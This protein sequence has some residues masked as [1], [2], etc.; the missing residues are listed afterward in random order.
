[1]QLHGVASNEGVVGFN[2]DMS[3]IDEVFGTTSPISFLS[4]D[5]ARL[6]LTEA[7]P[8]YPGYRVYLLCHLNSTESG[9]ARLTTGLQPCNVIFRSTDT[10]Q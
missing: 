2:R 8:V 6:F 4:D 10:H 1:M 5:T 9:L 3:G 7:S